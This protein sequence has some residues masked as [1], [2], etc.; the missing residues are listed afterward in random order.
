MSQLEL[1]I[2]RE[3][4]KKDRD[5]VNV[6]SVPQRSPFRYPGGKTWLVPTVR[7]WL[8]QSKTVPMLIEPFA[9]GGIVSLTAAFEGYTDNIIMSELD[10]EVAA[11]WQTI[12]TEDNSWLASAILD[13]QLNVD[14]VNK[15]IQ[16][17]G[18]T[19]KETALSTILK[20]RTYHGGI[21][22]KGSGFL[23]HGENGK[24]IHSRWYPETLYKRISA[25]DTIK[26]KIQFKFEDAFDVIESEIDNCDAY[27]FIDPP[28]VKAAKRLYS[29][30]DVD[31]Q[32]LFE[33]TSR[34][35]GRFLLT[36]DDAPEVREYAAKYNLKYKSIPMRT[37]HH[38]KKHELLITDNLDWLA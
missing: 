9:G 28:Y 12:L 32:R 25:I 38:L 8:S 26:H 17:E 14:N 3:F 34:I 19:I 4:D 24:G 7:K 30:Y 2:A 35:Q 37:T 22:T 33:L 6:S 20:N 23:K 15:V 1:S 5:V 31:H 27:F 11:V 10:E 29:L 18:K 13:F 36:Y 16:A 21:I